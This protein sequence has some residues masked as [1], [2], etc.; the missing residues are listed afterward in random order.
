MGWDAIYFWK[1]RRV[2]LESSF[3]PFEFVS[4]HEREATRKNGLRFC[5]G[6]LQHLTIRC[7]N[8]RI[9]YGITDHICVYVSMET[10]TLQLS[11]NS[12]PV[13]HCPSILLDGSVVS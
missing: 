8:F 4:I 5:V 2:R 1:N 7:V 10:D 11:T 9:V 6:A 12:Q 3:P 13:L